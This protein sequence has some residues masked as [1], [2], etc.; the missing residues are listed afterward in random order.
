MIYD[1]REREGEGWDGPL[2][3]KWGNA[4]HRAK[5]LLEKDEYENRS[6]NDEE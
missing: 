2:V 5:E 6:L 3:T 4:A 1:I